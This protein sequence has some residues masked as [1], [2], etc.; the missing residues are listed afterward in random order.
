MTL[1]HPHLLEISAWPWLERLS[2]ATAGVV[3]LANVP[4]AEWDRIA[5]AGFD[6]VFLMGVWSRSAIGREI[7]RTHP[8]LMEAYERVLPG[9][10]RDDVP[11][12]P[13]CIQRYEPDDRMGGWE[14]LDAARRAL[15]DRGISLILDFVPNHTAFDHPWIAE[16]PDRYV[17]GTADDY[18]RAPS[19]FRRVETVA[20]PRVIACGRDPYFAPWTDVAQLNYFNPETRAAM[21]A[22]L[23]SIAEHCDGVRCDMAML[24]LNDVFE[25]TWSRLLAGRW[26]RPRSE[27]WPDA[28]WS[29]PRLVYL[30]EVYWSLEERLLDQGFSYAYDKRLLDALHA[31]DAAS[32]IRDVLASPLPEPFRLARFIENHDEQRSAAAFSRCVT[33]AASLVATGPGMR[34]FFDGQLE[35]RR[36][37]APVQLARWPDE[38]IHEQTRSTYDRILRFARRPLLHDGEW[39][40]LHVTS[41]GDHSFSDIVAYRW[42]LHDEVAVIVLNFGASPA[43]AHVRLSDDLPPGH[44]FD[45]S[46]ALT[47][48][49]YRWTRE[50]LLENGLYVR[51]DPGGAHLFTVICTERMTVG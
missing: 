12:S 14:G 48:A 2:R 43:Q 46:D 39:Q 49:R 50:S 23:K 17:T 44:A 32:T 37:K 1:Q 40:L 6:Y 3:T 19:D 41:A 8:Q 35:G 30:A 16:H 9:W 11:G 7:A 15:S 13:Y 51:L 38:P 18:L 42:R 24:V 29:V 20:G 36:V 28:T 34:F 5:A 25:G 33:A 31:R 26:V 21:Q 45:F 4:G 47:D 27:F 10:T 22:T